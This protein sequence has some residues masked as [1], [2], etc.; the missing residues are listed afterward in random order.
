MYIV[1]F[2]FRLAYQVRS[3]FF[4]VNAPH[5][6]TY[7]QPSND[8]NYNNF[9]NYN[10][11][12]TS[13][14]GSAVVPWNHG[15]LPVWWSPRSSPDASGSRDSLL[16][17][18]DTCSGFSPPLSTDKNT[19]GGCHIYVTYA[20]WVKLKVPYLIQCFLCDSRSKALDN[21]GSGSW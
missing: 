6:L 4:T 1:Y 19:Y 12:H 2:S 10:T 14:S 9:Y 13:W 8:N 18:D 21:L 5:L 16:G 7:T 15:T 17:T 3:S 11:T 20:L